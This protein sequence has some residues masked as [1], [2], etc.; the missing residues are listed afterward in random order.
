MHGINDKWAHCYAH[1]QVTR[2]LGTSFLVA[3]I[4]DQMSNDDEQDDVK[5]NRL[6]LLCSQATIMWDIVERGTIVSGAFVHGCRGDCLSCCKRT[7][8]G[9]PND[10]K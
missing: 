4:L 8:V 9:L 6:E 1:C 3:L 5:A 10:N 2:C 7:T